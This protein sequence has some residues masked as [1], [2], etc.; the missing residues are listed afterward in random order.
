MCVLTFRRADVPCINVNLNF[1]FA[2]QPE[3]IPVVSFC[4]L[5]VQK[6]DSGGFNGYFDI[7]M[8]LKH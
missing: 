3:V 1:V 7:Y 4:N 8:K 2:F 6:F 5:F